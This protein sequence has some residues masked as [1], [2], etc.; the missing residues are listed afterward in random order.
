[1]LNREK[2]QHCCA[3][4]NTE[5]VHLLATWQFLMRLQ[6][7]IPRG[8][9]DSVLHMPGCCICSIRKAHSCSNDCGEVQS[10]LS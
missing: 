5:E 3:C 10:M 8:M 9:A 6:S 4:G 2:G 7:L 1:M